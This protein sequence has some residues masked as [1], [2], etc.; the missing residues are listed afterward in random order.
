MSVAGQK[1]G[2]SHL[3]P[4]QIQILREIS[5]GRSMK[6]VARQFGISV[7]TVEAHRQNVMHRLRIHH[8]PGLVRYALRTG[9]LPWAWLKRND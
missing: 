4:R 3:T 9:I 1:P 6:V 8:L 5:K 7:K 2:R